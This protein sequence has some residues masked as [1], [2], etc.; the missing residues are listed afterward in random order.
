MLN[1]IDKKF[2]VKK[3][4]RNVFNTINSKDSHLTEHPCIVRRAFT[5]KA[6]Q[7]DMAAAAVLTRTAGTF[8]P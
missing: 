3:R 1:N 7:N 6:V 5:N 8:V 2:T 4:K